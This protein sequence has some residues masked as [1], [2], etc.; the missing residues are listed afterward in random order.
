MPIPRTVA[1]F[2]RQYLNPMMLPLASRLPYMAVVRHRGRTSGREYETPILLFRSGDRVVIA[3]TYGRDVDWVRNVRAGG[4]ATVR[5]RGRE[6]DLVAPEIRTDDTGV[7]Q[8]PWPVRHFLP[9]V[10]V[11]DY[12]HLR[13]THSD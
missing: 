9:R 8:L 10:G 5:H 11:H 12:L 1:R 7:T 4:G 6:L 2:N 3:L 13:Q